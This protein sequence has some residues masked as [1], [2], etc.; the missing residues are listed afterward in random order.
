MSNTDFNHDEM[1]TVAHTKD[2]EVTKV[3]AVNIAGIRLSG[4]RY[5]KL[6]CEDAG[7]NRYQLE[8]VEDGFI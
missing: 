4:P 3:H 6:D 5:L 7:G 8:I 1:L 2:P